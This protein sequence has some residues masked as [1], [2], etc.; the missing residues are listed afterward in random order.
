LTNSPPGGANG[1]QLQMPG[2][3]IKTDVKL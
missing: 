1:Q 2:G 3:A